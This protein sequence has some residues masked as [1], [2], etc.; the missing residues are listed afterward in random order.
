MRK[1]N[2]LMSLGF[3]VLVIGGLIGVPYGSFAD[4]PPPPAK[5]TFAGGCFWCMEEAFEKVEGVV[6]AIS[7][8][9]GGQVENPTYEQVSAGG[10]GHTESIEVTYDPSK[11][12][13]KQLLE[14]FWRN[15]D[16]TTPNAQFCDHGN[17]YRTA[18]FYHDENQKQLIDESRQRVE[19][20]KTFPESIVTEIAPASVFYS[21]EEYHQDFYTKN[22]I[23]YKFYKW[24]CGRAQRLEQLWGNS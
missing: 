3:A 17:Q 13:Y 8:Y 19:N 12:T 24:N 20:S 9:T 22:P 18:I 4:D 1:A 15:V 14:V 23:R 5:A 10:T 16:P 7:G 6:S 11:V 21:A 2:F